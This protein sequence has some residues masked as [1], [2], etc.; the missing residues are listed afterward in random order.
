MHASECRRFDS[1]VVKGPGA[2]DCD[3]FT[4]AI[5]KDGYGRFFIYRGGRGICVR[6]NRY[7]LA[8]WLGVLLQPDELGLHE[9]DHP[10]CVKVCAPDALFQHV[11]VGT[12]GDNMRRMARMRRGGGRIAIPG[13]G[14]RARRDRSVALRAVLRDHGWDRAAV[15]SAL[16]GDMPTLW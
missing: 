5:G 16:L 14:L 8:R 2:T 4:G 9:C 10:L 1:Y 7:A 15:E 6:P 11:V 13:A 12:Q 3:F